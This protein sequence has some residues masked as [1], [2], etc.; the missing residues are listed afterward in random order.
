MIS[1][2]F[3]A[4]VLAALI[5]VSLPVWVQADPAETVLTATL[6]ATGM[7]FLGVHLGGAAALIV[8]GAI[9]ISEFRGWR[10]WLTYALAGGAI[11]GGAMLVFTGG[12]NISNL[13]LLIAAGLAGGLAYWLIAGRNAGKLLERIHAE[14]QRP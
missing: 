8:F 9:A 1:L 3:S 11:T 4:A 6:L 13:A 2:G 5:I 7:V 14:R 12:Q 10:D